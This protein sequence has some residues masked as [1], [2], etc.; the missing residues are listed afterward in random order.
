M[1]DNNTGAYVLRA[2]EEIAAT[3]GK[4][5][6]KAL[7]KAHG[8]ASELFMRTL[9]LAYDPF[10]NYGIKYVDPQP[11]GGI[12]DL[13]HPL[14]WDT[15]DRL[16]SRK[17]AGD[18]AR[19]AV[20]ELQITLDPNSAEVFRRVVH[21]DLRAGFSEGTINEV[22]K[23]T[24]KESPYMRCTLP[25]KSNMAAWDWSDVIYSQL[26]AD[27]M[28]VNVNHDD[29]GCVWVTSRQG[30]QFPDNALVQLLDDVRAYLKPGTQTHGEL[31]VCC[32]DKLL[33]RQVGNGILNSLQQGG[34][35]PEGHAVVFD[36]WDQIP[37]EAV[38]PKGT[39]SV[40]YFAR[41]AF[42]KEQCQ[43]ATIIGVVQTRVVTSKAEAYAHYREMLA[44]GLEGT[45]CKHSSMLW[46]DTGS[47]G[48]K[49]QV[50]LKLSADFELRIKGFNPGS[51]G[52]KTAETF[53]SLLCETEC[54]KLVVGVSGIKDDMRLNMHNNRD[55][56]ID[57]I[58]TARGNGIMEPSE[59][60]A[61][62]SIFLPRLVEPR[63]DKSTADTLEQVKDIF[64]AAMEAA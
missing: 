21:K 1:L 18:G 53:G 58:I 45:V 8:Q 49:D 51:P 14:V 23:G 16:A 37:L 11:W 15:L 35:M 4:N 27:G 63:T 24:F 54:G 50:K 43:Y 36:A 61:P 59:D 30:Q 12:G 22:F 34:P 64:R 55:H 7:V 28:F 19:Q 46:K 25:E 2:I 52:T 29:S 33:P 42:L 40:P 38:V 47:G 56:F 39:Y 57:T 48:N 31:T 26:K 17:L 6:K 9:K 41:F 10:I 5:D 3:P 44:Q 60:G 13:S 62:Y 32:D 20:L